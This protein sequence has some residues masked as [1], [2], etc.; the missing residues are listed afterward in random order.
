MTLPNLPAYAD[1]L[2]WRK[3]AVTL[4]KDWVQETDMTIKQ[5]VH[6]WHVGKPD[7]NA[8]ERLALGASGDPLY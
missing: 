3:D 5:L 7:V 8:S 2:V 4:A 6:N 1:P